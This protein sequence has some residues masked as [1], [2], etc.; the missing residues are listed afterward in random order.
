[1]IQQQVRLALTI[2][3]ANGNIGIATDSPSE[4]LDVNGNIKFNGSIYMEHLL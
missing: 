1:M 2:K 3:R 4:K